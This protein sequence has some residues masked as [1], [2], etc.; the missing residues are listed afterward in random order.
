MLAPLVVMAALAAAPQTAALVSLTPERSLSTPRS[1]LR[2]RY[3]L[4]DVEE[5]RQALEGAQRVVAPEESSREALRA[6]TGALRRFD[7]EA[8][9]SALERAWQATRAVGPSAEGRSLALELCTLQAQLAVLT[10]DDALLTKAA[11]FSLSIDS[12]WVPE[13][14]IPPQVRARLTQARARLSTEAPTNREVKVLPASAKVVLD[15][16]ER[17]PGFLS[18]PAA[19]AVVW[20]TAVGYDGQLVRLTE[21]RVEVHL[22]AEGRAQR[23]QP[24]VAAV[25]SAR[26][27][28]R[29]PAAVALGKELAVAVV[30]LDDG[31][32]IT[33]VVVDAAESAPPP[34]R[35]W[36][37]DGL[38]GALAIAGGVLG[39]A[40]V[41][42]FAVGERAARDAVGA[43]TLGDFETASR[44]AR[45]TRAIGLGLVL[46][47][48]VAFAAAL[49]RYTWVFKRTPVEVS[50]GPG[51]VTMVGHF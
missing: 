32:H 24:L 38:G 2:R 12:R 40:S 34:K 13:V 27:D 10:D 49:V 31:Q 50:V 36:L 29:R 19:G 37:A 4:L 41:A 9:R 28:A 11:A 33:E 26:E 30:L 16:T 15:G 42:L 35:S 25:R 43:T 23:L 8:S 7:F 20:L 18:T 6:L 44:L 1:E 39:G 48:G 14:R 22:E 17:P 45:D 5:V 51:Q 46:G 47:A 21:G 3:D